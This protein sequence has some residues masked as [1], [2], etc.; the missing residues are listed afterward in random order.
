MRHEVRDAAAG[1]GSE[2][3]E[4]HPEEPQLVGQRLP[5]QR[6]EPG[7]EAGEPE[8]HREQRE[9]RPAIAHQDRDEGAVVSLASARVGQQRAIHK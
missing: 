8:T 7:E 9:E 6:Q 4:A 2:P 3:L 5:D 1:Q